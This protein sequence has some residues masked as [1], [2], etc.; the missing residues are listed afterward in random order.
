MEPIPDKL[1]IT[2]RRAV[3]VPQVMGIC[4]T[5][6]IIIAFAAFV[7]RQE[8]V[9]AL[10]GAAFL[11]PW[12]YCLCMTLLL[13]LLHSRRAR[14]IFFRISPRELAAG[15]TAQV[16]CCE[17]EGA[18][19]KMLQLPG[20]LVRCRIL[21]STK[22]GRRITVDLNPAFSSPHA[23]TAEKR[24]AYFTVHEELAVFDI[25]GFFRF[26]FRVSADHS[27]SGHTLRLLAA[28]LPANEAPTVNARAGESRLSPE[29]SFQRADNLIDHRPYVPGDDPRRINWKLFG[30]AGDLFVRDD[31][32]EKPPRSNIAIVID[33]EYDPLLYNAHSGRGGIDVLCEN[34]LAA[35]LICD[36]SGMD[37]I[38]VSA[39]NPRRSEEAQKLESRDIAAA[40]AW[41]AAVPLP[42]SARFPGV[43][44]ERGI[45]ILALPRS[46]AETSAL[47]RFLKEQA[48]RTAGKNQTI[49]ILFLCSTD[50]AEDGAFAERL[51]A[52]ETCAAL[53]NRR[54]GVRARV[55]QV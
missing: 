3:F 50:T 25:L 45:I 39:D 16:M 6:I 54:S 10:I 14:R 55:A 35:A 28:P 33:T 41:P 13:A 18:A 19:G 7:F 48:S 8:L 17:G 9:L 1:H 43:P 37:V 4:I 11:L 34:A 44:E 38:I 23:F 15:E 20:I 21:L 42:A 46:S 5:L 32:R 49:E 22:D 2:K 53:Y 47:E 36:E 52:A 26:A 24:G 51:A 12:I 27:G 31:E 30:H 40:L 29:F